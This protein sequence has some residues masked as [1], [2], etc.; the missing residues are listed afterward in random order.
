MFEGISVLI[1]VGAQSLSYESS[2]LR[3]PFDERRI[4]E[5][6]NEQNQ[7]FDDEHKTCKDRWIYE[8]PQ[9]MAD[10]HYCGVAEYLEQFKI[11]D[12]KYVGQLDKNGIKWALISVPEGGINR[13]Q[14]G[15]RIGNKHGQLREITESYLV[16]TEIMPDGNG[17]WMKYCN[18]ITREGSDLKVNDLPMLP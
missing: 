8:K 1:L 17:G 15:N 14:V 11:E 16:I 3:D 18:Y 10:G 5:V 6:Q 2:N 13:V 4:S 7:E 9:T 12:L